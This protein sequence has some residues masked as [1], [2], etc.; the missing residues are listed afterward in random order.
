MKQIYAFEDSKQ[1][2]NFKEFTDELYSKLD[3]YKKLLENEYA[4]H[5]KPKGIIWTSEELATTVFSNVPIPAFTDKDLI[6]M[7]PDLNKWRRL[8]LSQLEEL[9]LPTI[10][11]FYENY[12]F[13][14]L[15]V[16][17]AHELTHHS[18]LF[19]DEFDDERTDSIWFEEGMCFYLPRKMLLSNVEFDEISKIE[20]ELVKNFKGKYGSHSLDNFGIGS[21]NGSLTSIMY[22]YWRSYLAVKELVEVKAAG[23]I[24]TVFEQY[25]QW[26]NEGRTIP[27]TEYFQIQ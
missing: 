18:D 6:Y 1:L 4:L 10:R 14:N 15:L 19:I 5:S 9:N 7:S 12:S 8:F 25:H 22:D 20:A 11:K 21:Y 27:L 16:I 23:N 2:T 17:L 3:V 26:H 13:N 24:K